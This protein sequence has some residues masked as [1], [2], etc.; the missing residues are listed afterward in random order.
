M[1]TQP[2]N[3]IHSNAAV[4]SNVEIG[5]AAPPEVA[6]IVEVAVTSDGQRIP[7]GLMSAEQALSLPDE[8]DVEVSHPEHEAGATDTYISRDELKEHW[9]HRQVSRDA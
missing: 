1:S 7:M 3:E 9:R 2:E 5:D 4:S 8:I 6:T